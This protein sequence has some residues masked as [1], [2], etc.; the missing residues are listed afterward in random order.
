[1]IE[2]DVRPAIRPSPGFHRW[3]LCALLGIT[4]QAIWFGVPV[5]VKAGGHFVSRMGSSFTH[6]AGLPKWIAADDVGYVETAARM[7]ADRQALRAS[8]SDPRKPVL[9]RFMVA[10]LPPPAA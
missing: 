5:V 4:L 2:S 3:K 7:A 9:L 8:T 6:A 1:M 10:P